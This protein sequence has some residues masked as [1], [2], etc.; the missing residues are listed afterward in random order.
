M[1]DK[2]AL[3][4]FRQIPKIFLDWLENAL[5][6]TENRS[7]FAK[8]IMERPLDTYFSQDSNITNVWLDIKT[9]QRD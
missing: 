5:S 9:I 1:T 2:I 6:P 7:L 8:D 4:L 3:Y